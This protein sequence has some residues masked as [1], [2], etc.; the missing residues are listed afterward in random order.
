MFLPISSVIDVPRGGLHL[1]FGFHKQWGL[2]AK[3]ASKP[4]LKC[5][6]IDLPTLLGFGKIK[7]RMEQSSIKV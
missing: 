2:H 6:D 4:Y 3:M 5:W 1:L 7:E